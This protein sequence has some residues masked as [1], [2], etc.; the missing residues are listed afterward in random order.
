MSWLDKFFSSVPVADG[1]LAIAIAGNTTLSSTQYGTRTLA[2]TGS[3]GGPAAITMPLSLASGSSVAN[4]WWAVV[5]LTNVA[6]TFLGTSGAGVVVP[7]GFRAIIGTDGSS[8]FALSA[9]ASAFGTVAEGVVAITYAAAMAIDASQ[10]GYFKIVATDGVACTINNPTKL[11]VGQELTFDIKNGTAG[12]MG[13]VTWGSAGLFLLVGGAFTKPAAGKRT[14]ITFVYDGTNL[15]QR[16]PQ[17][18]DI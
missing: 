11:S 9:V 10:G 8:F 1:Y 14:T 13:N 12:V 5:N 16:G 7:S 3:L 4:E 17:S 18:G 15:V 2:F 6:L